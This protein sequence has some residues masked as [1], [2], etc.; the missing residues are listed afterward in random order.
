VIRS[1]SVSRPEPKSRTSRASAV[2]GAALLAAV[3]FAGDYALKRAVEGSMSLGE[4]VP[5]VP[6]VVNLTYIENPGG[7]FG[8]LDGN[9]GI[10][11]AGSAVA[12]AAVLWMLLA[13]PPSR[14]VT[15]GCGLVLGGA[16]GNL[17]DRLAA[18]SVVDY[19]DLQFWPLESWPI[20]NAADSAIVV[21]AILLGFAAFR[22]DREEQDP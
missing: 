21:G 19:L 2:L 6:G 17:L 10:L 7:A 4:S 13:Y 18:G 20:F 11:L 12:V 3:T 5:L 8:I 15:L 1:P 22:A 16:A 9:P 14:P